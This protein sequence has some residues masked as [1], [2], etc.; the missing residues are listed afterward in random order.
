MYR[1][2]SFEDLHCTVSDKPV[3]IFVLVLVR[4]AREECRK[5][6]KWLP[7]ENV[8]I[9][10]TRSC[11]VLTERKAAPGEASAL[12]ADVE[13]EKSVSAAIETESV[14]S[15][16]GGEDNPKAQRV[17][18]T[19][20]SLLD[21]KGHT[22]LTSYQVSLSQCSLSGDAMTSLKAREFHMRLRYCCFLDMGT[23]SM[24]TENYYI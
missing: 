21:Y 4:T 13:G 15:R 18:A 3:F 17:T 1:D 5:I 6:C 10:R 7:R 20:G 24:G 11:M 23:K 9:S 22:G 8:S 16:L 12:L 14:G 19:V 2:R